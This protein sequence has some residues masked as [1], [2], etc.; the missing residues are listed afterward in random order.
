[1]NLMNEVEPKINN[2]ILDQHV[3]SK[4]CI[5]TQKVSAEHYLWH[6]APPDGPATGRSAHR[7]ERSANTSNQTVKTP[8]SSRV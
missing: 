7:H 8:I 2:R 3:R 4:T 5:G 1:M 6:W